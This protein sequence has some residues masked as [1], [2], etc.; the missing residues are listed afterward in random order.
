M[1]NE[2]QHTTMVWREGMAFDATTTSGHHLIVDS[3]REH[4]GQNLGPKPIE[5]L[6]TALAGCT[7]M[8]VLSILQKKRE[9]LRGL[10]VY[11]EGE[12]ASEHPMIYN[13]IEIVYRVR[14]DVSQS[15][16]AR[17]IELSNTKYCGAHAMLEKSAHI[18]TRFEILR[19]T[20]PALAEPAL[21]A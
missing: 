12:R 18:H 21:A 3:S 10:E 19:E 14:G 8:D 5:L 20:E 2:K 15:A 7:A 9:P 16:V 13:H 17:A 4:G 11:V 6:L 1:A